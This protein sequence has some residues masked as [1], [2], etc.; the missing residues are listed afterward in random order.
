VQD[1]KYL[2]SEDRKLPSSDLKIVYFIHASKLANAF[3]FYPPAMKVR[4]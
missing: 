2:D 1:A 3:S 4:G